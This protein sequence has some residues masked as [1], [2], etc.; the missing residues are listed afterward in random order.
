MVVIESYI[1]L[2]IDSRSLRRGGHRPVYVTAAG[3][4]YAV[5]KDCFQPMATHPQWWWRK[6]HHKIQS[7]S[8]PNI[9]SNRIPLGRLEYSRDNSCTCDLDQSKRIFRQHSVQCMGL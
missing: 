4:C 3:L 8:E 6:S 7:G 9:P 2:V 1:E 5:V